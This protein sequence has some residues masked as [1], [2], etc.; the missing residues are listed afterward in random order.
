MSTP[1]DTCAKFVS[2]SFR[3]L[4]F[5]VFRHNPVLNEFSFAA[6]ARS[7]FPCEQTLTRLTHSLFAARRPDEVSRLGNDQLLR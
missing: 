3:P 5:Q 1:S 4:H 6:C 7:S 2:L